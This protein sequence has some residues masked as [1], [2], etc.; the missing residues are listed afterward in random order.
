MKYLNKI[1]VLLIAFISYLGSTWILFET[2]NTS[3][4]M[5]ILGIVI[6]L[7]LAVCVYKIVNHFVGKQK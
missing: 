7:A 1:F 4:G 5:K 3:D 6:S 2:F